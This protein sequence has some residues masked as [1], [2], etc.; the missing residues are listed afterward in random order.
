[1]FPVVLYEFAKR[2]N[3]L[4]VPA[5]NAGSEYQGTLKE[6]SGILSPSIY[7]RFNTAFAPYQMNYAY[8][9]NFG[10]F[11]FIDE[12]TFEQGRWRADMSVD[13][14]GSWRTGIRLSKQYVLRAEADYDP[15]IPDYLYSTFAGVA[16]G[17]SPITNPWATSLSDGW[18]ILGIVSGSQLAVTGTAWY[19]LDAENFN[20]LRGK[21]FSDINWLNITDISEN[22]Q[23]AL[24]N[25]IQYVSSIFWVP[26]TPLTFTSTITSGF[27]IGFWEIDGITARVL[28]PALITIQDYEFPILNH[29]QAQ[30]AKAWLSHSDYSEYTLYFPP[31]GSM[32][33]PA[34]QL[35]NSDTLYVRLYLDCV[36]KTSVL[37][38]SP[39]SGYSS[40]VCQ[41]YAKVGIEQELGQTSQDYI[42]VFTSTA[43]GIAG[44]AGNA[45]SGNV[46][47]TVAGASGLLQGFTGIAPAFQSAGAGGGSMAELRTP[48][49]LR[50]RWKLVC[51]DDVEHFGRPYCKTSQIDLLAGYVL[52]KDAELELACTPDEMSTIVGYLNNG[53]YNE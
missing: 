17:A 13:A 36:G 26:Y 14:M 48:V 10:R 22:L 27:K 46:A 12:W 53:F 47:G 8:I 21:L 35:V 4:K 38:A 39:F 24:I 5:T 30:F 16:M 7:F 43:A 51:D 18:F 45:I 6:D 23:K 33:I 52:C 42:S 41:S 20:V 50:A 31:F 15:S 11:Y 25:P 49:E 34:D 3:S 2:H 1:M 44:M 29:P 40:I 19:A 32:R 37:I 9:E 28:D